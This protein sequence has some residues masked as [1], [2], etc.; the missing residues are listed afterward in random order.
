MTQFCITRQINTDANSAT[1]HLHRLF[2]ALMLG[3]KV[4]GHFLKEVFYGK[5]EYS[6][7]QL[8]V[9]RTR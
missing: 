3:V 7:P 1:L 4:E 5:R 2:A 8:W 6:L 9:R